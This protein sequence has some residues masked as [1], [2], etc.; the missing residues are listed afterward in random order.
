MEAETV[1]AGVTGLTVTL[2]S[3]LAPSQ[4]FSVCLTKY[5]IVPDA[6]VCGVGA[7]RQELVPPAEPHTILVTVPVA[8]SADAVSPKQ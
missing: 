1:G 2:I 5:E 6:V 8:V 7:S 4:P 3:A